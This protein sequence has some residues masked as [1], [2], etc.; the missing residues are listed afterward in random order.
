MK[1]SIAATSLLLTGVTALQQGLSFESLK[2]PYDGCDMIVGEVILFNCANQY[3]AYSTKNFIRSGN[4]GATDNG[5]NYRLKYVTKSVEESGGQSVVFL[6]DN[7][8]QQLIDSG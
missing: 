8:V 4:R 5:A 2:T 1:S 7:S 6:D 3:Q